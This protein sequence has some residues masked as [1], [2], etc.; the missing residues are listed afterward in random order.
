ML[1]P[2][3]R[4]NVTKFVQ[5]TSDKSESLIMNVTLIYVIE[6]AYHIIIYP[7]CSHATRRQLKGRESPNISTVVKAPTLARSG[8]LRA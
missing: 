4:L 8:D 3:A 5:K 7:S 6:A 1:C 2:L